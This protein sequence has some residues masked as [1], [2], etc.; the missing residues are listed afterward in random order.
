[1]AEMLDTFGLSNAVVKLLRP[2]GSSAAHDFRV[3]KLRRFIRGSNKAPEFFSRD[4]VFNTFEGTQF[5]GENHRRLTPYLQEAFSQYRQLFMTAIDQYVQLMT[6]DPAPFATPFDVIV[7]GSGP[8]GTAVVAN[9]REKY[10]RLRTLLVE[11]KPQVGGQFRAYGP[12]PAYMMNSRVRR[13]D[14]RL[15]NLPRTPGSINPLGTYAPL[16]LSDLS[17][18]NYAMNTD[19][20]DVCAVNAVMS[21]DIILA[22]S[23]VVEIRRIS[24]FKREVKIQINDARGERFVIATA[25]VVVVAAGLQ[26][27]S[28]IG[29]SKFEKFSTFETAKLS[30]RFLDISGFY[31]H[32]ANDPIPLEKFANKKVMV[33]GAGDSALTCLEALLGTLPRETYGSFGVGRHRP[34]EIIWTN[35]RRDTAKGIERCLRS[36]YKNGI[37][38]ALPRETDSTSLISLVPKARAES[39]ELTSD[40]VLVAMQIGTKRYPLSIQQ[41]ANIVIDCTNKPAGIVARTPT[42]NPDFQVGP[43]A[44]PALSRTAKRM[45]EQLKIKENMAAL[46]ATMDLTNAVAERIGQDIGRL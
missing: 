23:T 2:V 4:A 46:W 43:A 7:I 15:P 40:G 12:K 9:L 8:H 42:W 26:Q 13:A 3:I 10:P 28:T 38:Q 1:M 44:K 27:N 45:V 19:M 36:R 25:K 31:E 32:F 6:G 33:V 37:V 14:R 39:A 16:E 17:V 34:S 24:D 11:S 35:S 30:G 20:G 29:P 5:D 41:A 18:G 21:A 22:N